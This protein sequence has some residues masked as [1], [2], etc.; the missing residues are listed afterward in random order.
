[1]YLGAFHF[2]GDPELLLTGYDRMRGG[3]PA[4][5]LD[6][7]VCVVRDGGITVY[8]ACPSAADF[9]EFTAGDDFAAQV[10]A[11][12]LPSPRVERLGEVRAAE[13]RAAVRR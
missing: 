1:M 10:A 11:A 2:D 8:D 3:Y 13:M 5:P 4:D 12:G 7:H 6:L 9:A